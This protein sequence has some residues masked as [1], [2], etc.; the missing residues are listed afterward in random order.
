MKKNIDIKPIV[1]LMNKSI[2]E[3]KSLQNVVYEKEK[4]IFKRVDDMRIA[5]QR[6]SANERNTKD[7]G[8]ALDFLGREFGKIIR[9]WRK[10]INP[11]IEPK[12]YGCLKTF[13]CEIKKCDISN[14]KDLC[15]NCHA[16]KTKS[17]KKRKFF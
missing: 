1:S 13:S 7:D 15:P 11:E 6:L 10:L 2:K 14:C 9:D 12:V 8:A 5:I 17:I 3:L 16:I 4:D